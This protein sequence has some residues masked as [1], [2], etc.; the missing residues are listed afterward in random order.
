MALNPQQ[1]LFKECYLNPESE[2][3]GNAMQSALKA[4]YS[5]D[6]ATNITTVDNEWMREIVGDHEMIK[7]AEKRLK[8][9]L[10]VSFDDDAQ[11]MNAVS[12]VATFVAERLGKHKWAQRNELTGRDGQDLL[13][14]PILSTVDKQI[15]AKTS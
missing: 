7:K 9:V 13:P 4:G 14:Q 8:E 1:Q 11:K 10:E 3:F 5:K 12:K 15:D 6:Y 2:T